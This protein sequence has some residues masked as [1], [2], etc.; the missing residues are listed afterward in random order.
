MGWSSLVT[1]ILD[2]QILHLRTIILYFIINIFLNI[3]IIVYVSGIRPGRYGHRKNLFFMLL[4]SYISL[5]L[6]NKLKA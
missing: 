4:V 1:D 6:R 2:P 3:L 5:G